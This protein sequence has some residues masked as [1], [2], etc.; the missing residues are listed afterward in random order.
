ML[1]EDLTRSRPL[2][3]TIRLVCDTRQPKRANSS[4]SSV[5]AR[6]AAFGR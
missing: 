5:S 4:R 1:L 3:V 6:A 2:P